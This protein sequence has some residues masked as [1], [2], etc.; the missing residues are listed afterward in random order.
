MK[1]LF[2]QKRISFCFTSDRIRQERIDEEQHQGVESDWLVFLFL[3]INLSLPLT[4]WLSLSASV[5][6]VHS[7][8]R[9]LSCVHSMS[10]TPSCV[11][12]M[13]RTLSCCPRSSA[14]SLLF[15]SSCLITFFHNCLLSHVIQQLHN[16]FAVT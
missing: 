7:M 6:C 8:S 16:G 14:S 3:L 1:N 15:S 9:T 11:H 12:S 13:S 4:L 10:R 5:S 2:L